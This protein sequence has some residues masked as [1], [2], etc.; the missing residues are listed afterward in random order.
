M[1]Y[2]GNQHPRHVAARLHPRLAALA[3]SARTTADAQQ[4]RP[5]PADLVITNGKVV[6]VEDGAPEAQAVAVRGS[7]IVAVGTSADM[8]THIGPKTEVIDVKGQLVIPGLHRGA[9][10]LHRH[11]HRA[12]EPESDEHEELG[13]DRGDGRRKVKTAKPGEWILGSKTTT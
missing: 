2:S 4:P 8:K 13:R 1:E 11:R 12:A 5:Q 6:T 10:P 3:F 9:R 7:R